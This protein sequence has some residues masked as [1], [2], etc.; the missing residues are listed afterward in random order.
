MRQI[1]ILLSFLLLTSTLFGQ[2]TERPCYI[3]VNASDEFNQ[4][5]LSNISISIISQYYKEIKPF[6]PGGL[7]GTGNC[8]YDV[9][10]SKEGGKT[11]VTLQ[12]KDM[13]S[14]GDSNFVGIDGFQQSLLKSLYRSLSDKRKLICEGYGEYLVECGGG[15]SLNDRGVEDKKCYLTLESNNKKNIKLFTNIS[16]SIVS[17][18]V[19]KVEKDDPLIK[20]PLGKSDSCIYE[21]V[22]EQTEDTLFTTVTG[23]GLNSYGDSKLK[24]IEG[25]QQSLLKSLFRSLRDKRGMICDDYRDLLEE[26]KNVVVQDVPKL[27]EP[28]VVETPKVISKVVKKPAVKETKVDKKKGLFV[29]VG[30][31]GTILTS[32]DGNWWTQRTSGTDH[33]LLGVTYGNGLFVVVGYRTILTSPDGNSWTKRNAGRR[34]DLKGVTYGNGLFVTVGES[35]TILTSS[36]GNSWTSRTNGTKNNIYG[37]TYGNGLFVTVGESGTIL[38]SSDGNSWTERTPETIRRRHLKGVTY[39]NGL[40]VTAGHSGTIDTSLDGNSWKRNGGPDHNAPTVTSYHLYGVTYGNG[41]FVTVG[42]SGTILTSTDG[43]IWAE[44]TSGTSYHLK[45]ITYSGRSRI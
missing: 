8:I 35:G 4:T 26:C 1:I 28:K 31:S 21:I 44:T 10:V 2:S 36:D 33:R 19:T 16:V 24:G 40:F 39:G 13:N 3:S 7:S 5:L 20:R 18:Y 12:G 45:I 42:H 9:S 23:E 37:V 41:T 22:V 11:F 32:P 17:Q 34:R 14:F 43:T 25:F 6:P 29:S 15:S 30:R 38:T 27:V